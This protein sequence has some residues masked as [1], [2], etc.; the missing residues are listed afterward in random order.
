MLNACY[1]SEQ[2]LPIVEEIDFVVGMRDS[3]TDDGARAFAAALYQGLAYRESMQTAFDLG[4]NELQLQGLTSD[5][6]VP[7]LLTRKGI[8]ASAVTLV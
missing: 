6:A 2:A 5:A 3:I 7:V 1:S 8:D 4:C